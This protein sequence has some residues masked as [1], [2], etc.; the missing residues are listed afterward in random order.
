MG[1]KILGVHRM[2]GL[3]KGLEADAAFDVMTFCRSLFNQTEVLGCVCVH[4]YIYVHMST[5]KEDLLN[6]LNPKP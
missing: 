1:G 2:E 6:M 4:I 3:L 5:H